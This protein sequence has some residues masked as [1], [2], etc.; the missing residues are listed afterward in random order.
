MTANRVKIL[1]LAWE[2]DRTGPAGDL[3][4]LLP[5][6]PADRLAATVVFRHEPG[7][8]A[9]ELQHAGAVVLDLGIGESERATGPVAT[10]AAVHRLVR[11]MRDLG[12]TIAHGLDEP[13]SALVAIAGRV[14]GVPVLVG[15]RREHGRGRPGWLRRAAIRRL[16]HVVVASE[17]LEAELHAAGDGTRPPTTVVPR[18]IDP[19]AVR[20]RFRSADFLEPRPRVGTFLRLDAQGP[21]LSVIE[22]AKILRGPFPRPGM[23]GGGHRARRRAVPPSGPG[24]R[25]RGVREA[26]RRP[27][28]RG[29]DPGFPRRVRRSRRRRRAP[30]GAPEGARRGG[31]LHRRPESDAGKDLVGRPR[32]GSRFARGSGLARAAG[33]GG[34]LQKPEGLSGRAF[35]LPAPPR[36]AVSTRERRP[37]PWWFSTNL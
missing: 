2:S 4:L 19:V 10:L 17:P 5:R 37:L 11:I 6:L 16:D 30:V 36:P 21:I 7:P 33:S 12:P 20:G 22:A 26:P 1:L 28:G 8:L 25:A 13:S 15:T 18:G 31:S 24:R 29:G 14:S 3:L 9:L 32:R 27:G 34:S 35:G 23:A